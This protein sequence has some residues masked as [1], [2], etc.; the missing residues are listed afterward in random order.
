MLNKSHL[1]RRPS[2]LSRAEALEWYLEQG[3]F[4]WNGDCIEV[5]HARS[6][7]IYA[8]GTTT[9]QRRPYIS[10]SEIKGQSI[11]LARALLANKGLCTWRLKDDP[12]K[13]VAMHSCDNPA[14]VNE[15]HLSVGSS[16]DNALDCVKKGRDKARR[17]KAARLTEDQ[18]KELLQLFADGMSTRE[19]QSKY[20]F[21][22]SN[23]VRNVIHRRRYEW[24]DISANLLEKVQ[25]RLEMGPADRQP[26]PHTST[27]RARSR[28]PNLI[29]RIL[30]TNQGPNQ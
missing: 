19:L 13:Q 6:P 7:G 15:E 18:V 20:G 27:T 9:E 24:V 8:A 4:F 26:P 23:G 5:D 25:K 22:H 28:H 2:G 11:C 12:T 30:E 16:Q 1:P 17:E 29:C 14:C 21:T 3:E 10:D